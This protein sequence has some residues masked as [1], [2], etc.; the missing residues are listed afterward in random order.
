MTARRSPAVTAL[1]SVVALQVG[2]SLP[3][4]LVATLAPYLEP[5]IGLTE[6][7]LGIAI[8]SFH[9]VS[10]VSSVWLGRLADRQ[11]WQRGTQLAAAS[12]L[13]PLV[14]LAG[15]VQSM[16]ALAI[17]LAATALGHSL[18]VS[19]GNL[20][21]FQAVP[22]ARQGLSFGVKQAAVPAAMMLAGLSAPLVAETLGWRAAFLLVI[23]FPVSAAV[24]SRVA[25]SDLL[26]EGRPP[27]SP[28][29]PPMRR[30]ERDRL[31]VLA[32]AIGLASFT[33]SSTGA[34]FVLFAVHRGLTPA[35]AGIVVALC[36]G[37]NI[38]MRVFIGWLAD[39]RG[40]DGIAWVSVL[41]LGGAVG[42]LVLT[43]AD[44]QALV[45]FGAVLAYGMGW[46]WQGLVHLGAVRLVPDAPGYSSGVIRTG[47]SAGAGTGPVVSGLTIA[48]VGY[49]GLWATQAVLSCVAALAIFVTIRRMTPQ[50]R[51]IEAA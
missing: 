36:S 20:A 41:L 37:V 45:A 40:A 5:D 11:T 13:V 27:D 32:A 12:T 29:P 21:V 7:S 17:V 44:S 38:V 24:L 34:F 15:A 25:R 49:T 4:F 16:P 43:L 31:K 14:L 46:A 33:A 2:V 18:A 47:M 39:R 51:T 8:A 3:A 26:L 50:V 48:Y 42:Y 6:R 9:A 35:A 30:E 1:G 22:R 19:T 23:V 10:S 28:P